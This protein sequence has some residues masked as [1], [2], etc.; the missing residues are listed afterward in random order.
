MGRDYTHTNYE[1]LNKQLPFFLL[2]VYL[3]HVVGDFKK[4]KKLYK[5]G[6]KRTEY[7]IGCYNMLLS[8]Y[9]HEFTL[10]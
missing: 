3:H 4:A 10:S 6:L 2:A 9:L 7:P 1:E 8:I 5:E